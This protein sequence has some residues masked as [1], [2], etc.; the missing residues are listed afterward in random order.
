[1]FIYTELMRERKIFITFLCVDGKYR[2]LPAFLSG[3]CVFRPKA[4]RTSSSS[5]LLLP[6]FPFEKTAFSP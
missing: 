2:W 5:L 3:F 1:V 6:T 4:L